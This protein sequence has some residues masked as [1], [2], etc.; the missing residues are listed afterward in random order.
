M[1]V[2]LA[3]EID[4]W[5]GNKAIGCLLWVAETSSRTIHVRDV[6]CLQAGVD[7]RSIARVG[8]DWGS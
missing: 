6:A 5:G 8:V 1:R 3:R 7:L 4:K 2:L